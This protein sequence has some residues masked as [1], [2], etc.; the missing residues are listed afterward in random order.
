LVTD[1]D[2]KKELVDEFKKKA[3]EVT[4]KCRK[5]LKSKRAIDSYK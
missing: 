1:P 2:L 4:F 3:D 5:C